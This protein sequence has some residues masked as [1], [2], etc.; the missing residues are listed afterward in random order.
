MDL[1]FK[2]LNDP[3]RRQLLD[4]LKQQ[5]G[6]SLTALV[7]TTGLT[8]FAVMKHLKVLEAAS[9]VVVRP[10]GRFKYHYL[11]VVPLQ[12][13]VDRWIEPLT[14][15]PLARALLDAKAGLEGAP[16]MT[17]T[18]ATA[19]TDDKPDFVLETYIRTTP[20]KLWQALTDG[21]FTP[22]YYFGT[23]LELTLESN[24]PYR[25]LAADGSTML[26]GEVLSVEPERR[27]EMT[28]LPAW[29]GPDGAVTRNVYEIEAMGESCRLTILHYGAAAAEAGVQQG[30]SRIAAG[31]KTLLE[32]GEPLTIG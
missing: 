16:D 28:F 24:T 31:L 30:W 1:I 5:D 26:S 19:S 23:T 10:S 32:T 22:Q 25:Y 20:A 6:Q 21:A 12:E 13:L 2:A 14:R 27:L 7:A 9:L 18:A 15:Q 3:T 29:T 11:N 8:R 17:A 4:E